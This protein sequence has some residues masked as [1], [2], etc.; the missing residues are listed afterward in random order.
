MMPHKRKPVL[1]V[2]LSSP[3]LQ[4]LNGKQEDRQHAYALPHHFDKCH[5]FGEGSKIHEVI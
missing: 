1:L 4:G 3:A 5:N 2:S